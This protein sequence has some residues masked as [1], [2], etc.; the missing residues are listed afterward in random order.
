MKL[1][2]V[3]SWMMQRLVSLLKNSNQNGIILLILTYKA[4]LKRLM[5]LV[6]I[7][8]R[9]RYSGTGSTHSRWGTNEAIIFIKD[10][11]ARYLSVA[12]LEENDVIGKNIL[13]IGPGDN[14]CVA[15]SFISTGAKAV[16]CIDRF[17]SKRDVEQQLAIYSAFRDTLNAERKMAFDSACKI[18]AK[19]VMINEKLLKY[20]HGISFEDFSRNTSEKF[21]MIVSNAVLEHLYDLPR[22]IKA[23]YDLLAPGGI[24]V[25]VVDLTDH[26]MFSPKAPLYFLTVPRRLWHMIGRES[27]CPNR[28]RLSDYLKICEQCGFVDIEHVVVTEF[29]QDAVA[30]FCR[31]HGF[32]S[33]VR[34]RASSFRLAAR[35]P[36]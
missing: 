9:R 28:H 13:E 34:W 19:K 4:V 10:V 35:K 16:T 17:Y 14:L 23:M 30:T 36:A 5:A 24:I 11:F 33:Q 21:D 1:V 2:E 22:A 27:D 25:H 32:T 26:K 31:R 6:H 15:L 29:D 18:Q 7:Q 8:P 12:N 20:V 3:P